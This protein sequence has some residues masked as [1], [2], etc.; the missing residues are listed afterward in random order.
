MYDTYYQRDQTYQFAK[1]EIMN[2]YNNYI[3]IIVIRT[4]MIL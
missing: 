1:G 2:I 3:Y 4:S